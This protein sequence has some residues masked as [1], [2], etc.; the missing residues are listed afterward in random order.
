MPSDQAKAEQSPLSNGS[1]ALHESQLRKERQ[2][3][4]HGL[5]RA[6]SRMSRGMCATPVVKINPPLMEMTMASESLRLSI[7]YKLNKK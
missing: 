1:L 2:A 6:A 3:R 5:F 4:R 7:L